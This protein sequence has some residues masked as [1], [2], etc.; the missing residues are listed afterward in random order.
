MA[1]SLTAINNV[2]VKFRYEFN[3]PS[4]EVVTALYLTEDL[5]DVMI[6][7]QT[8]VSRSPANITQTVRS[9]IRKQYPGDTTTISVKSHERV[10]SVGG[11]AFE[12]TLPGKSAYFGVVKDGPPREQKEIQF[13]FTGPFAGLLSV[14]RTEVDNPPAGEIYYLRSPNGVPKVLKEPV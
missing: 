6:S 14:L 3:V 5:A 8:P 13:Q 4:Q 10:R 7:G 1:N 9:H 12:N 2:G 11:N